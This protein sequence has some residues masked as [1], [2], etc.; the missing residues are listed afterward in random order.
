M[1]TRAEIQ[2]A[3][4]QATQTEQQLSSAR[5]RVEEQL[6]SLARKKRVPFTPRKE[7]VLRRKSKQELTG[8]KREIAAA[9]KGVQKYRQEV[10]QPAEQAISDYEAEKAAYEQALGHFNK[11]MAGAYLYHMRDSD[12]PGVALVRKYLNE[13]VKQQRAG[14]ISPTDTLLGQQRQREEALAKQQIT[15]LRKELDI[16]FTGWQSTAEAINKRLG[17]EVAAPGAVLLEKT[18]TTFELPYGPIQKIDVQETDPF[19]VYTPEGIVAAPTYGLGAGGTQTTIG[20]YQPRQDEVLSKLRSVETAIVPS[21]VLERPTYLPDEAAVNKYKELL[22]KSRYNPKARYDLDRFVVEQ[23]KK[24]Q[25]DI[26]QATAINKAI[27]E[28]RE[29]KDTKV[30]DRLKYGQT[31]SGGRGDFVGSGWELALAGADLYKKEGKKVYIPGV[32]EV[33]GKAALIAL[34]AGTEAYKAER[35]VLAFQLAGAGLGAVGLTAPAITGGAKSLAALKFTSRA[36]IAALGLSFGTLVGAKEYARTGDIGLALGAG[37]GSTTG[38]FG[39]V[40]SKQIVEAPGKLGQ[41]IKTNIHSPGKVTYKPMGKRGRV[42]SR[43]RSKYDQELAYKKKK[44]Q[45]TAEQAVSEFKRRYKLRSDQVKL[46]EDS[47]KGKVY[48]T[49][50]DLNKDLMKWKKFLKTAG[51]TEVQAI[52]R[53][54]EV[55]IRYKLRILVNNYNAGLVTP[56]QFKA[57]STKLYDALQKFRLKAQQLA[58]Q[59]QQQKPVQVSLTAQDQNL[60]VRQTQ[61]QVSKQV[62]RALTKQK[63]RQLAIT[64]PWQDVF[65]QYQIIT[66]VD[67]RTKQDTEQTPMID[68]RTLTDTAQVP[69]QRQQPGMIPRFN[70]PVPQIPSLIAGPGQ[71]PPRPEPPKPPRPTPGSPGFD[72]F[73]FDDDKKKRRKRPTKKKKKKK[74]EK[75]VLPTLTQQ[76]TG[77]RRR[78]PLKYA[79]GFEIARI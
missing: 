38:Y 46:I 17:G 74:K 79:T 44:A 18:P 42:G 33:S 21:L 12:G 23:E 68:T 66:K 22:E 60:M 57:Q 24:L 8:V 64:A 43:Q 14:N 13:L 61:E 9:E 75:K 62:Q 36:S 1:A 53:I 4:A 6:Q 56:E 3:K 11:G 63:A 70:I 26:R 32:G 35:D 54:G 37:L 29:I 15:E 10:I 27:R 73:D 34:K 48:V 69:K 51:L 45:M 19:R 65:S 76:L 55:A 58:I 28:G 78:R 2:A 16:P 31:V 39:G 5:G 41:W 30:F 47:I 67:T 77:V 50:A 40:Y 71:R 72:W 52:D 49:Q 59:Q 25:L 20:T 7:R